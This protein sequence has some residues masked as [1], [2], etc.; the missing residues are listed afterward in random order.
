MDSSA[1]S[2]AEDDKL[3]VSQGVQ[4]VSESDYRFLGSVGQACLYLCYYCISCSWCT[5]HDS[6]FKCVNAATS[7]TKAV[8]RGKCFCDK[9]KPL[10]EQLEANAAGLDA[11]VQKQNQSHRHVL[12]S[13]LYHD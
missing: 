2:M 3:K 6:R 9:D 4:S 12:L 7:K 8:S 1:D 11:S 10:I 5:R 13:V